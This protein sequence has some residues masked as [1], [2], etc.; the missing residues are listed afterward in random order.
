MSVDVVFSTDT[1]TF[2]SVKNFS[3]FVPFWRLYICAF[4]VYESIIEEL[5]IFVVW[6]I[7]GNVFHVLTK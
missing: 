7:R 5:Y 6:W 4:R 3:T 2:F 1:V